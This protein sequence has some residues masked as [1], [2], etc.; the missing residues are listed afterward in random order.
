MALRSDLEGINYFVEQGVASPVKN[1]QTDVLL[2][3]C[4]VA[5]HHWVSFLPCFETSCLW[6]IDIIG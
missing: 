5:V 2:L 6:N 4:K 3:R 1:T